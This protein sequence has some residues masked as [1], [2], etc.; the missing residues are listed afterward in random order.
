LLRVWC[1]PMPPTILVADDEPTITHALSDLLEDEGYRVLRCFNGQQ[2]LDL[3]DGD[4]PDLV[5]TDVMMPVVDGVTLTRSLRD[6]GNATPVVL[7]SAAYAGVDI[8]GIRFAP[9]PFDL[10]EIVRIVGRVLG[11]A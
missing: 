5:I 2:A 11:T 9:K 3:I 10:D 6:R 7:M 4:A 8:P 1:P